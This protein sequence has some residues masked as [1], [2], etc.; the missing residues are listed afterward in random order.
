MLTTDEPPRA[1][2]RFHAPVL[3]AIGVVLAVG[4]GG[5]RLMED[6]CDQ[7]QERGYQ[8]KH[9]VCRPNDEDGFWEWVVEDYCDN[10]G[11]TCREAG[12]SAA[13]V[14]DETC[15]QSRCDGQT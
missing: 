7:G 13:C 4:L 2:P 10:G 15:T 14:T 11:L 12:G 8:N 6:E 5:C 1:W 9:Q 3:G